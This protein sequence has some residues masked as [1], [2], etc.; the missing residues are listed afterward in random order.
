[1]KLNH[2]DV[3][4][5]ASQ[6]KKTFLFFVTPYQNCH[7]KTVLIRGITTCVLGGMLKTIFIIP[8]YQDSAPD[9]KE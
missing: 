9:K 4:F 7:Y 6:K 8:S 5:L 3:F 2:V 1:M